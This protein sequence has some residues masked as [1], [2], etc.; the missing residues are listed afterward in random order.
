MD[1][2]EPPERR[3][4]FNS[5]DDKAASELE[6]FINMIGLDRAAPGRYSFLLAV[7]LFGAF[8]SGLQNPHTVVREIMAL[9]AGTPTGLK[10]PIQNRHPPLKGLWHKH[11]LQDGL[12]SMAMNVQQGLKR[13]GMPYFQQKIK[14][15]QETGE[16]RYVTVEDIEALSSDVIHG[17][18]SRLRADERYTGEWLVFARHEGLNF[19]LCIATHD[20]ST[21]DHIRQLIDNVCCME[22]PFLSKLLADA[23]SET[24]GLG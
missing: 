14:E 3:F 24:N 21:H 5:T 15:A 16:E 1:V 17:N 7:S 13:Y 9:E 22:F 10:A 20:K 19:Y 6:Q 8:K 2:Q 23:E 18:L 12:R 4:K 11:Y